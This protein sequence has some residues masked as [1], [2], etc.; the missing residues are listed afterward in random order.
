MKTYVISLERETRRRKYI[1]EH[2]KNLNID[3]QIIEAVDGNLL[4][5]QDLENTCDIETVTRLRHWLTNGA[6]GCALSHLKA[7]Q[8]FLKTDDKFAFIIEDDAILPKNIKTI[9]AEA[10]SK[11][12]TNEVVLLHY[13]SFKPAK[14][15]NVNK[16][17]LSSSYLCFPMD[18]NQPISAVAYIIGRQAASNLANNIIPIKVAADSWGYYYNKGFF[19]SFRVQFPMSVKKMSFKSS[20]DYLDK[21][22]W[23]GKI[24]TLVDKYKIPL[25]Y[26]LFAFRRKQILNKKL[27][28]FELTDE[29]SP[30]DKTIN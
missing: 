21:T 22:S 5:Q 27:G 7:Y 9:L 19:D 11:I 29:R 26:Q 12:D 20:I 13:S 24:S 16:I 15:S 8:E 30:I 23:Q 14:L 6:I 4:T 3:Y 25:L 10:S 1:T 18:V 2:C 28:H 17:S